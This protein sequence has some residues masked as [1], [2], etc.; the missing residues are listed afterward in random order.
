MSP[1]LLTA[2]A[3]AAS[4]LAQTTGSIQGT[5]LDAVGKPSTE[6][7]VRVI[8]LRPTRWTSPSVQTTAAGAFTIPALAPGEYVLCAMADPVKLQVDPCFWL[9]PARKAITVAAGQSITAQQVRLEAGRK[10][11]VG[12]GALNSGE[13]KFYVKLSN[14]DGVFSD[15]APTFPVLPS[16]PEGTF[17][18]P[19]AR[20]VAAGSD[21][22][23]FMSRLDS[24]F[25]PDEVNRYQLVADP[26]SGSISLGTEQLLYAFNSPL[27]SQPCPLPEGSA[28]PPR[29]YYA[30]AHLDAKGSP[31]GHWSVAF[32]FGT[33]I[34]GGRQV[35]NIY[36]C[37]SNRRCGLVNA[38]FNDQFLAGVAVADQ[39][40]TG[41]PMH[42]VSYLTF[43][44][45]NQATYTGFAPLISQAVY[46]LPTGPG[47][48]ATTKTGIQPEFWLNRPD[49]CGVPQCYGAGDYVSISANPFLAASIPVV[50]KVRT[51]NGLR[52]MF[53]QDPESV[54]TGQTFSLPWAARPYGLTERS[55]PA[56]RR[57]ASPGMNPAD[58]RGPVLAAPRR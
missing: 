52:Q 45:Y 5:A 4:T 22:H 46:Y 55:H 27:N 17:K 8:R 20:L 13:L 56:G 54:G 6:T 49:K 53:V 34:Q 2:A 24:F 26:Q 43:S 41:S 7:L 12:V 39:P 48:G 40:G 19:F 31:G 28:C 42:W 25:M 16:T 38:S 30:G 37:T 58:R 11:T 44:S 33:Q 21:F 23:V 3:F 32:Q 51:K 47:V 35:N 1:K 10:I 9:D 18:G 14:A 36:L 29:I 50:E 15:S 57:S